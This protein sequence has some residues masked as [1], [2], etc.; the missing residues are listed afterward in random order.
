MKS[1]MSIWHLLHNVKST[2]KLSS[3]FVAFLENMDFTTYVPVNSEFMGKRF[4][5]AQLTHE[6]FVTIDH[7]F[8]TF[9]WYLPNRTSMLRILYST[10]TIGWWKFS[11]ILQ[12]WS[13][14]KNHSCVSCAAWN[15][16]PVNSL[17][18][19]SVQQ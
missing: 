14:V 13:M 11:Y 19:H 4:Q 8:K 12:E 17:H 16:F 18:T 7:S 2:V 15:V 6:R 5:A 3:I 1:S 9:F 10:N